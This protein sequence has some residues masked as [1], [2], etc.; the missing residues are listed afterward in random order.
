MIDKVDAERTTDLV[1]KLG[2]PNILGAWP[3]IAAGVIMRK[4]D[5]RGIMLEGSPENHPRMNGEMP[6]AALLQLFIGNQA[7]SLIEED[8]AQDFVG[9]G[10]HRCHQILP[11]IGPAGIDGA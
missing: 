11:E 2:R 7:M 10:A 9:Q 1:E 6:D 4:D 8:N 5:R 3:R